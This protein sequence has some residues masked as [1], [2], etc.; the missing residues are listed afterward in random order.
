[1][2]GQR[3]RMGSAMIE[4]FANVAPSPERT[5]DYGLLAGLIAATF[6]GSLALVIGIRVGIPRIQ[7]ANA[8]SNLKIVQEDLR[9]TERDLASQTAT[10]DQLNGELA[11]KVGELA[12][13]QETLTNQGADLNLLTNQI[14]TLIS[15]IIK[16]RNN[17]LSIEAERTRLQGELSDAGRANNLKDVRI[18]TLQADLAQA[19]Q[20]RAAQE[21][22]IADQQ[23]EIKVLTD[24]FNQATALLAQLK[25]AFESFRAL[26]ET[27]IRNE[28]TRIQSD[29]AFK[30]NELSQ[31]QT[32]FSIIVG[33]TPIVTV[34]EEL[35]LGEIAF[36]TEQRNTLSGYLLGIEVLHTLD[37]L[38]PDPVITDHLR[39]TVERFVRSQTVPASQKTRFKAGLEIFQ[40]AQRTLETQ[41]AGIQAEVQVYQDRTRD[42]ERA[43]QTLTTQFKR[44]VLA[45]VKMD[46]ILRNSELSQYEREVLV[47]ERLRIQELI[48]RE[49]QGIRGKD[50]L[51]T[52]KL[53]SARERILELSINHNFLLAVETAIQVRKMIFNMIEDLP[54]EIKQAMA[55][56]GTPLL[57]P[58]G[59][60]PIV[61][62][63]VRDRIEAYQQLENIFDGAFEH[64]ERIKAGYLSYMRAQHPN[65]KI[66][67]TD[68][69]FT[70]SFERFCN[71][72]KIT[73]PHLAGT[74]D[75]NNYSDE[76]ALINALR[77][78]FTEICTEIDLCERILATPIPT[79]QSISPPP[80]TSPASP[81][82]TQPTSTGINPPSTGQFPPQTAAPNTGT[83]VQVPV[84]PVTSS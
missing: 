46:D 65:I 5:I 48:A 44:T 17:L 61:Q 66:E 27:V 81:P 74:I 52:A 72:A 43:Y 3:V 21:T 15:E 20:T 12:R 51:R 56:T 25:E 29:L 38:T 4:R 45:L 58:P 34:D 63:F 71:L 13:A 49:R 42:L 83:G 2:A 19:Q 80:A 10:A 67:E 23:N 28:L 18:Q 35:L 84:P 79:P 9:S 53:N 33:N 8:R 30:E 24:S 40:S 47:Q 75:L 36:L 22:Q 7:L 59:R 41:L 78:E 37:Q 6:F 76:P 64:W 57:P 54:D 82:I 26:D 77:W 50:H 60:S 16:T 69:A 73:R 39:I 31:A 55:L 11:V 70:G 62:V 68:P 14:D 1:M 32:A